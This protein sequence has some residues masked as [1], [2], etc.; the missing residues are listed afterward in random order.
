MGGREGQ[1][2]SKGSDMGKREKPYLFPFEHENQIS[3]YSAFNYTHL[4]GA[5]KQSAIE[6]IKNF[7]LSIQL[8]FAAI[9]VAFA[10]CSSF[11]LSIAI[12]IVT[13]LVLICRRL[14]RKRKLK[15]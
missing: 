6:I 15:H 10:K 7:Y 4:N 8:S 11:H 5:Q 3:F 13:L 2:S 14:K 9:L 12:K 1:L